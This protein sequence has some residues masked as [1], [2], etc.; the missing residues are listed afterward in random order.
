MII[1]GYI[2]STWNGYSYFI[3]DGVI[4]LMAQENNA[5]ADVVIVTIDEKSINALGRWPWSREYHAQ[6]VDVLQAA[7]PQ[8][9]GFS[10]LFT[11][12]GEDK[13]SDFLLKKKIETSNFPVVMPVLQKAADDFYF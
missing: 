13:E 3:Y 12:L 6:L 7:Q 2:A 4:N 9:L 11:E 5:D 1:V 8:V 10:I